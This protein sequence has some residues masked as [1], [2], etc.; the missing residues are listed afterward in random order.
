V[1]TCAVNRIPIKVAI[2]DNGTLGM[3]RQWQDLFYGRRFSHTTLHPDAAGGAAR[4]LPDFVA[5]AEAM[6]CHGLRCAY[7]DEL[8]ATIEKALALD[9]APVVVDFVVSPDA[10][11][12]PMV[13]AGRSN[14]DIMAARD[15]RPDFGSEE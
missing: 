12:W 3:V 2:I 1:I 13:P 9:D 8:D 11:V 10:M 4:R 7:P 5:L 14:D 15:V 6:G